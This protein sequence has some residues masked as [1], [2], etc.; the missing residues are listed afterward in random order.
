MVPDSEKCHE[1]S[2]VD[3]MRGAV[4]L[5]ISSLSLQRSHLPVGLDESLFAFIVSLGKF[6]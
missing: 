3:C 1:R 4:D 6:L 2:L 5:E